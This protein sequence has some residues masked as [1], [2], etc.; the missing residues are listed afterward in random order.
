M[1]YRNSIKTFP[2]TYTL[3]KRTPGHGLTSPKDFHRTQKTCRQ[4]AKIPPT[5]Q[6]RPRTGEKTLQQSYAVKTAAHKEKRPGTHGD[7]PLNFNG[8]SDRARTGDPRFTR[9]VLCQL[10]YAGDSM[11]ER[12][13]PFRR[14]SIVRGNAPPR[15]YLITSAEKLFCLDAF[16]PAKTRAPVTQA[17]EAGMPHFA[18]A[19]VAPVPRRPVS[20]CTCPQ[21]R[22][23]GG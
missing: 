12:T 21:L 6:R 15:K 9:A 14:L 10:S 22:Q 23:V 20:I 18:P 5:S 3:R 4:R 2:K 7:W 11:A 13:E 17:T 8:A 19:Q 16:A 1:Q